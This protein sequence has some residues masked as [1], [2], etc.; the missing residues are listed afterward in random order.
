MPDH[1]FEQGVVV[2]QFGGVL[3]GDDR[4]VR[5]GVMQGTADEGL[6]PEV[7]HSDGAFIF[8]LQHF[9]RDLHLY[10]TAE[11]GGFTHGGKGYR[12]LL[13]VMVHAIVGLLAEARNMKPFTVRMK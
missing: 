9:G 10:G 1:P 4:V 5:E 8:L 12:T 6:A 11:P 2:P 7:R 13:L 3:F